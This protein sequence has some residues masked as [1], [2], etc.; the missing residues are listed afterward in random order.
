MAIKER[1]SKHGLFPAFSPTYSELTSG[2]RI[3]NTFS[4]RFSFNL[5][6]KE[7]SNK[8][9]IQQLDSIVIKAFSS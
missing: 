2:S 1:K 8:S 7:K 4:D 9:Y 6:I 3:I 5:C